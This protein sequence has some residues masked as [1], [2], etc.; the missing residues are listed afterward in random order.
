LKRFYISFLP[1]FGNRVVTVNIHFYP[2][3]EVSPKD[4]LLG[5][6]RVTGCR[7]LWQ[8][9]FSSFVMDEHYLLACIRSIEN[10]HVHAKLA[11]QA[12]ALEQRRR[13]YIRSK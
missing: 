11:G 9:R 6:L 2:L 5:A 4:I 13:P 1:G 10:N 3:S 7:H 8:E 12:T